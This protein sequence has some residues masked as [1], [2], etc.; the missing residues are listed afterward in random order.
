MKTNNHIYLINIIAGLLLFSVALLQVS[1]N[2][3]SHGNAKFDT[4]LYNAEAIVN[5]Y[6]DSAGIMLAPYINIIDDVNGCPDFGAVSEEQRARYCLLLNTALYKTNSLESDSLVNI[7]ADYYLINK[8]NDYYKALTYLNFGFYFFTVNKYEYAVSSYYNALTISHGLKSVVPYKFNFLLFSIYANLG[9]IYYNEN[10]CEDAIK[11]HKN[12]YNYASLLLDDYR[13]SLQLSAIARY[14]YDIG[15]LDSALYYVGEALKLYDMSE[16]NVSFHAVGLSEILLTKCMCYR[17]EGE[18]DSAFTSAYTA[19][20][21]FQNKELYSN[22]LTAGSIII[23]LGELSMMKNDIASAKFYFNSLKTSQ[24]ECLRWQA[25]MNL[26]IIADEIDHDDEMALHYY[27]EAMNNKSR[28]DESFNEL[29]TLREKNR[30]E[31]QNQKAIVES[32]HRVRILSIILVSFA[33]IIAILVVV[34]ILNRRMQLNKLENEKLKNEVGIMEHQINSLVRELENRTEEF[35]RT[36]NDKTSETAQTNAEMSEVFTALINSSMVYKK[37]KSI[38][39]DCAEKIKYMLTEEDWNDYVRYVNLVND[40]FVDKIILANPDLMKWD[41]R[42]CCMI[43]NKF[44]RT[45]IAELLGIELKSLRQKVYRM[46]T[47]LNPNIETT[48]LD[49][50]LDDILKQF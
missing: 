19:Y 8:E 24:F 48:D 5:N 40:H 14:H 7:A 49:I 9:I 18:I 28:C 26:S 37:A 34:I 25:N 27:K 41:I 45:V 47:K 6:P 15:R 33:I 11:M 10:F 13:M 21:L 29:E 50:R 4:V 43:K 23:Q 3:K 35:E 42:V 36:H 22:S 39:N 1:C 31:F 20:Q 32:K 38:E 46:K 30:Y 17:G 16:D 2:K 12:A 44:S